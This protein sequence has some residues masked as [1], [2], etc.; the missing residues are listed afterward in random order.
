[1]NPN[2]KLSRVQECQGF[3]AVL[4]IQTPRDFTSEDTWRAPSLSLEY[5][6]SSNN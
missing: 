4:E 6:I 3:Y 5:C 2:S 1:M